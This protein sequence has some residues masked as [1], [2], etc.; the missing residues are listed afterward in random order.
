[1]PVRLYRR[2]WAGAALAGAALA[3]IFY[4]HRAE[5]RNVEV[6]EVSLKLPRLDSAFDGYRLVQISD[7]H[8][9]RWMTPR[10]LRGLV[11]TV[12]SLGPDLIAITGDLVTDPA[13]GREPEFADALGGLRATDG[14]VAVLGNY[15][16]VA[17]EDIVREL[18]YRAGVRELANDFYTVHRA[19]NRLHIAGVD[20][21]WHR[22]ARLD[23]LLGKM[24]EEGAAILLAHEPDF[25]DIAA[26]TRR[27][28]L[29]LSGHT[30]GGQVR[31]PLLGPVLRPHHGRIYR[32]GLYELDGVIQYTNRGLG[33]FPPRLRFRCR[34]EIT[35]FTLTSGIHQTP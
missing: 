26:A 20:D 8:A 12:N 27:F 21:L 4:A 1:M 3:V 9:D 31:L 33:M 29:Q 25:A 23:L 10:R 35:V 2:L 18:L 13:M 14:P 30:H 16:Y 24:P 19:G 15:D 32:A 6:M 17:G 7:L 28:E 22:K 34:P 11:E 5:P